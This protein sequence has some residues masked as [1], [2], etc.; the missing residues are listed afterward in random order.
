M[1]GRPDAD[2]VAQVSPFQAAAM[3]CA[4]DASYGPYR[5][6][7]GVTLTVP[8]GSAVALLGPNGAGKTTV[9]RVVS[10]LLSPDR[11]RVLVRGRD[12]T[13]WPAHRIARLGLAHVPE[14]RGVF[15]GLSVEQNLVLGFTQR[16]GRQAVPEALA[17]AYD[18]FPA[19]AERRGQLA[20]SLSGGQQRIL[21]LAK[22]L[23]VPPVVLVA[24]E[25]SLG[26][27][28]AMVDSVVEALVAAKAAGTAMLV[29]EQYVDRALAVADQAVVLGHGSVVWQ[30]P[31]DQAAEVTAAVAEVTGTDV[32]G[33]GTHTGGAGASVPGTEVPGTDVT[34]TDV[35]GTDVTGTGAHTGG[36]GASVPGTEVPGAGR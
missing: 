10:G 24:D 27:A 11:G 26:L 15:G 32:T 8:A 6:L 19:L 7:F 2:L 36:A 18:A 31:A 29:V 16:V 4:V 22:V 34:G 3:L 14:G 12:V 13:G 5:A 1:R 9:A 17:R 25:L 33:T 20:G 21:S 30:G 28:P 23:A 35:T